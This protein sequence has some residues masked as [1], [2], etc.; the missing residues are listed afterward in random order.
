MRIPVL[1]LSLKAFQCSWILIGSRP[2]GIG[3]HLLFPLTEQSFWLSD[4]ISAHSIPHAHTVHCWEPR[5]SLCFA[6]TAGIKK[7]RA[8]NTPKT[9]QL[10]PAFT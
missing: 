9:T 1:G 3:V 8:R 5:G 6:V 2:E 4:F 10:K 7:L